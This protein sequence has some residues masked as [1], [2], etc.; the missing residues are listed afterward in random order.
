[1]APDTFRARISI[2]Y[3]HRLT[4]RV[5]YKAVG[6]EMDVLVSGFVALMRS[7]TIRPDNETK[8][9]TSFDGHR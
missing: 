1:M 3:S 6:Y 2:G 5:R 7:L 8:K 4:H 9:V